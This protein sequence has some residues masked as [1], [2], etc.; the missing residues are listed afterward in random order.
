MSGEDLSKVFD[1]ITLQVR[2]LLSEIPNSDAL[3]EEIKTLVLLGRHD[4]ALSALETRMLQKSVIKP[5][6]AKSHE[7][8]NIVGFFYFS[9]RRPD[10]AEKTYRR[11]YEVLLKSQQADRRR[12][13]K[14]LPLHNLGFSIEQQ[15]DIPRAVE[16]YEAAYIEDII[17]SDKASTG[18]PAYRNLRYRLEIDENELIGIYAVA[19][20]ESG[21]DPLA[22]LEKF[23]IDKLKWI[24]VG[25]AR[26]YFNLDKNYLD[27]LLRRV[28][29]AR[30][31]E[32]KKES[33]EA[34]A[35]Y[36]FSGI[37]G[38]EVQPTRRT[39]TSDIDR[40]IRNRS[41][42]PDLAIMGSY[43]LLESKNWGRTITTKEIR[44]LVT[45]LERHQ[46]QCGILLSRRGLSRNCEEEI[47]WARNRGFYVL[48][49]DE[50][51][52]ESVQACE[53]LIELLIKKY[54]EVKFA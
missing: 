53:N 47:R 5:D 23:K 3:I 39:S 36:M 7:I 28:Q 25:L 26:E 27:I 8:W 6:D 40:V 14:G 35:D 17:S 38:F 37:Q 2:Q 11:F 20:R 4:D 44:D 18:A 29:S 46:C 21:N 24:N 49:L 10:V 42:H 30:T 48:G 15:G 22:I 34:L 12:Y 31:N 50:N 52:I 19:K 54:E 45:K 16:Y 1:N 43:I 13:H 33:L 51:E 32:E 41:S 9:I